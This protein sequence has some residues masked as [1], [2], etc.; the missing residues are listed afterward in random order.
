MA[1]IKTKR[2]AKIPGVEE[3]AGYEQDLDVRYAHKLLFGKSVPEVIRHFGGGG[4]I[5]RADELLFMPRRAFQYYV[6]AFA[7]YLRTPD[8][9]GNAD[10]PSAFLRLLAHREERDPGSVAQ[11]YPELAEVI[12]DVAG[13]QDDY[14]ADRHIYGDFQAHAHRIRALCGVS[15]E[16]IPHGDRRPSE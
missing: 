16:S 12:D 7:S 10:A 2:I 3:W 11:I 13:R 15:D 5:E 8:A 6:F 9:A 1:K 4:S 14:G